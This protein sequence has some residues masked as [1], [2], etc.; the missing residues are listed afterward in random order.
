[1]PFVC[2][3]CSAFRL[4]EK[5]NRTQ[6][7]QS[8]NHTRSALQ[9]ICNDLMMSLRTKTLPRMDGRSCFRRATMRVRCMRNSISQWNKLSHDVA[10]WWNHWRPHSLEP[11]CMYNIDSMLSNA[12]TLHTLELILIVIYSCWVFFYRL[13]HQI[14]E[15]VDGRVNGTRAHKLTN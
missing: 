5:L 11:T 2:I 14:N 3:L 12:H 13:Q 9:C 6:C 1:M 15:C 8:L 10:Q 4:S 7:E